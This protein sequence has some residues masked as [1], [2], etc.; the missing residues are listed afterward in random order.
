MDAVL[1][2]RTLQL[3]L[4]PIIDALA[5]EFVGAGQ[6]LYH[7][8]CLEVVKTDC[9]AVLVRLRLLLPRLCTLLLLLVLVGGNG[10]DDIFYFFRRGKGLSVFVQLRLF[11]LIVFLPLVPLELVVVVVVRGIVHLV[12][13][14]SSIR[15]VELLVLTIGG[16]LVTLLIGLLCALG[17]HAIKIHVYA[18]ILVL[19]LVQ[20]VLHVSHYALDIYEVRRVAAGLVL[21]LELVLS[22]STARE[23]VLGSALTGEL[24]LLLGSTL[25]AHVRVLLL[26]LL[27]LLHVDQI[28]K[29]AKIG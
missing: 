7:L 24:G 5:V 21:L 25:W 22:T 20:H 17:E 12:P 29:I 9:T 15:I 10:V 27:L 4:K 6:C 2:K 16:E 3:L 8:P 28:A 13:L 26:L 14:L 23:L 1:A 19:D 18:W 11:F